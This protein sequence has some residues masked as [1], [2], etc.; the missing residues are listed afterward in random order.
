MARDLAA[1]ARLIVLDGPVEAL[2]ADV[3]RPIVLAARAVGKGTPDAGVVDAVAPG[4]PELGVMLAYTPLHHLLM[5]PGPSGGPVSDV[6]VMTSANLSDEPLCYRDDQTDRLLGLADLVL[7]HDRPI[8]TPCDDSVFRLVD[9]R[10]YPVRRS[11]GHA[12]L[13]VHL[14]AADQDP[15]PTTFAVGAELKNT[16]CVLD[17][18]DA[19][20][21]QHL[22]D[23]AGWESQQVLAATSEHVMDLYEVSPTRWAADAHPSYQTRAWAR[24]FA[25]VPLV[26]VQHHRAH[27][28][29][30]LAE[31]HLLGTRVLAACF[32]GTGYGDDGA[33]WGGEWLLAGADVPERGQDAIVRVGSLAPV[34][35]VGGDRAVREPWRLALAHLHRAGVPW[36]DDLPPVAHA[37]PSARQVLAQVLDRWSAPGSDGRPAGGV[38]GVVATTSMGRLFDAVAALLGVRQEIT[39][40]AQAAIDLEAL[41]ASADDVVERDPLRWTGDETVA[42]AGGWGLADADNPDDQ[43]RRILDPVPVIGA[44]VRGVRSGQDRAGLAL[45]FH[46][47]VCRAVVAAARDVRETEGITHVGLT[48]GVFANVLLVRQCAALLHD[49]GFEVVRHRLVPCNDGGLSVGQAVLAAAAQV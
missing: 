41:A 10:P 19:V 36:A 22:G 23:M 33:A 42:G 4:A 25:Q 35:M 12:P 27:V 48:G 49:A 13:P 28:A 2:L 47:W 31:Q 18:R 9:G 15:W 43:R 14:V 37:D 17:G 39:Y 6:L 7:G 45:G 16:V 32:D 20:C 11:R 40:E 26:E 29:A 24:R 30:L 38:A 44:L 34:G 21:S 8:V 46:V 1:A 3:A 5:T